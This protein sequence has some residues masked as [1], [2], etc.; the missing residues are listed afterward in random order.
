[1]DVDLLR[2]G[3]VPISKDTIMWFEFLLDPNILDSHLQ[4]AKPDPSPTELI[5]KFLTISADISVG[6][7]ILI[8]EPDSELEDKTKPNRR[9]QGL[10]ILALKIAAF[11]KWDLETLELK[12]PFSIQ[13]MLLQDLLHLVHEEVESTDLG[14]APDHVVFA[15]SLYHRWALR[16]V[17]NNALHSKLRNGAGLEMQDDRF[18]R[19]EQ[20][21]DQSVRILMDINRLL[22]GS[23]M[24]V[25]SSQTFV[26]LVEDGQNEKTPNW[27]LGTNITSAEFF[28]MV[29]MDLAT[30]L[31]YREDYTLALEYFEKCKR[32]FDKW[33]G[34]SAAQEAYCKT[35]MATI[36]G[37][38]TACQAPV[39]SS[40]LSLTDRFM[41][42]VN[43]HYEG[44]LAILAEDNLKREVPVSMRESL[45]LDIAAAI[46][47]GGFTATRDLIF[48][49]QSLNTVYKR[50]ADL[51]CIYDYCEKLV[52]ARR[53]VEIFVWA[54][55]ATLTELRPDEREQLG[56][57][58][59]ELLENVDAGVQLELM[60]H[61]IVRQLSRDQPI[62]QSN[63][64]APDTQLFVPPDFNNIQLKNGELENQLINS[65]EP[66]HIKEIIIKLVET[67]AIRPVWQIENKWELGT[68]LHG[69]VL[70]IPSGMLQH[71]LYVLLGKAKY[72]DGLG[73][74]EVARRLLV[75]AESEVTHHGGMM[76]LAQLIA[77][78][79][80]LVEC[81]HLHA[82]WP[83]KTP[84]C[85]TVVNRCLNILQPS[86][87]MVLPRVEVVE[88]AAV[89]LLNLG[90]WEALV[91]LAPDKR[92]V[93]CDLSAT[94][95]QACQ[96][97][98]KY[99]GNKKISRGAW[100]LIVPVFGS[101]SGLGKRGLTHETHQPLL[102]PVLRLCGQLRDWTVLSAAISLLARLH[103]VLRDETTLELVCEHT[104]LWPSVVSSTNS[105]NIQLVSE[106][107]WQLV[108]S[109]LEYY[110]KNIS[111]HK[112]LGDYYYVGEHYSAAVKQYL[113]AAVIATDS[114]SR[115]LTKAVME[116]YVYKRMI[117]CLSQLHCH[118][119][120]GVLCQF[121]EEVDY[122]TAFKSFTESVCHD[123]MDT[124]Y[125]CIWDVNILEYLIYLQNK[126]GNKDRAKKA[127]DMIGLLE[128]NA[129]NNEEIKREAANK[130]KIRFMQAL[131]RQYVL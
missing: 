122:N 39:M 51:P 46:S 119:Q 3:T 115:P 59:V 131:V 17:F 125:D 53:G 69:I 61:E 43:N 19:I 71:Y 86:D 73:R 27:T 36:E 68:P 25:P 8:L 126:K 101:S 1:M 113:L 64:K 63:I 121:L 112:L 82:E 118:T 50:A 106:H 91:S 11:L 95:A 6:K 16:A 32:E 85:T 21:A 81:H 10:K 110:P 60:G 48:Q 31:F 13:W 130:R 54:L 100:D 55:K 114:F 78:E 70:S 4:K 116:D 127:I 92:L 72:L 23:Q 30:Y 117:K 90:E 9:S 96:D 45:E 29:L 67:N 66:L 40:R 12:L 14:K 18:N 83:N 62:L 44:I 103:N 102:Q 52:A 35:D 105:Y 28:T 49:I 33:S 42:S 2:P 7:D 77:W 97:I 65:N 120:A 104:A 80:L 75:A 37:Y 129:N 84:G 88:T 111:L 93:L 98:V 107:L 20:E 109:A 41:I 94:L 128:L 89:T 26:P 124:Y 47:S 57:F 56:L 87:M 99:K 38:I 79:I 108:N 5:C 34:N 22:L 58:V 76:K 123:C 24:V 74:F 15:V